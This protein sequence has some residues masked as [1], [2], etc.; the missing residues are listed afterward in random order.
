M[1]SCCIFEWEI[2]WWLEISPRSIF[3]S[4]AFRVLFHPNNEYEQWAPD[5]AALIV[6]DMDKLQNTHTLT[7]THIRHYIAQQ[8]QIRCARLLTHSTS[9][10]IHTHK[11]PNAKYQ[12]Q[13]ITHSICT[14]TYVVTFLQFSD[15]ISIKRRITR[16]KYVVH[17]IEPI[18]SFFF[19]LIF[20]RQLGRIGFVCKFLLKRMHFS[21]V[22]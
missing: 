3:F 13:E 16:F 20:Y 18:S 9:K 21:T 15:L 6:I 10:Y 22:D 17:Q 8:I 19:P 4:F 11:M 14:C 2:V 12:I 7:R 5:I 1:P